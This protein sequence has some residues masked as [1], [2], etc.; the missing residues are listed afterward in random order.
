MA[1]PV[2]G[3]K[4]AAEDVSP[5]GRDANGGATAPIAAVHGGG[6]SAATRTVAVASHAV[7][8][9][10]SSAGGAVSAGGGDAP[11][12]PDRISLLETVQSPASHTQPAAAS[13]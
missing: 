8:V 9:T 11:V 3:A 7:R 12:S 5:A 2:V 6:A 1:P 10:A 4:G 13:K